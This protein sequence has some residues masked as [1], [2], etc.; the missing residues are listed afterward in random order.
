MGEKL[1][2]VFEYEQDERTISELCRRYGI[3]AGNPQREEPTKPRSNAASSSAAVSSAKWPAS[4][5]WT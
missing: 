2:F 1:R 5:T 4:S 3:R